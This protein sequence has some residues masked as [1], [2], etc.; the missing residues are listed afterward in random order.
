MKV[1]PLNYDIT[2]DIDL[3]N[4]TYIGEE[5]VTLDIEESGSEVILDSAGLDIKSVRFEGVEAEFNLVPDKQ[6]LII[7]LGKEV[8]PSNVKVDIKFSGKIEEKLAGFYRSKYEENGETK[9]IA[10]SQF[11]AADARSAFPCFDAPGH[12]ATFDISFIIDEKLEGITNTSI[13][14]EENLGNGKKLVKFATTPKMSTYILY[15]GVGEFGFIKD[16]YN[17]IELRTLAIAG[18]EQYGQFALDFTK[19]CLAYFED[20]FGS[21]YVLPK[22]DL[23]AVPDFGAGAMENWGAITFRE[24]LLLV[25]PGKTSKSTLQRIAEVTAHELAHMW[26]GNLVTMKWWDNLWLNESFATFMAYKALEEIYPE[27][28][29][30]TDYVIHTNFAGMDLDSLSS[31]HP[32]KVEVREASEVDEIFDAISY[33]KGGSVLRMLEG[34]VGKDAFREGLREYIK[35]FAYQNTVES[36][37]WNCIENASDVSIVSFMEKFVN[38][39]GFPQVNIELKDNG[40]SLSQ[41]RFLFKSNGEDKL[42]WEIP[43]VVLTDKSN[44][45]KFALNGQKDELKASYE[46]VNINPDYTGFF[47]SHYDAKSLELLGRNLSNLTNKDRLGLVHDL[48][49]LVK[50]SRV[51]ADILVDFI[52]KYFS[53]E[54]DPSVLVY[55]LWKLDWINSMLKDER[56]NKVLFQY[57]QKSLDLIGL[58][59]NENQKPI[60]DSLRSQAITSLTLGNDSKI[61]EFATEKFDAFLKDQSSLEADLRSVIYSAAVW[62][63]DSHYVRVLELYKVADSQ[64]EKLKLLK[65]LC[66]SQNPQSLANTLTFSLTEE[67]RFSHIG[68]VVYNLMNNPCAQD[69]VMDWVLEN[70]ENLNKKGGG[71]G[72]LILKRVLEY[73]VPKLGIGRKEELKKFFSG[74]RVKGMKMT[75]E[76]VFEELGVN[77]RLVE[78]N[79]H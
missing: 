78:F 63:D 67:V 64:E 77:E 50:A 2:L 32:I 42:L 44:K 7:Q 35:K 52:E 23:I 1:K 6:Q 51:K 60:E 58:I 75:V 4:F 16:K 70:W 40:I 26:F 5:I 28:D 12:K 24:N 21:K 69:L 10:T 68:N 43:L 37:L 73:S 79:S 54:K 8:S 19:K 15:F 45:L 27:W 53:N 31:S 39:I 49:M 41:N 71:M 76:Q 30:W 13:L 57:S 47:I 46:I 14:E 34:Y 61:A 17:D 36:D 25:Y 65:A 55:I 56:S 38:Q 3:K 33:D 29:I 59:P 72:T 62:L 74:D 9:Y 22:L 48:Y 18:K 66:Y 11:E 20:Y